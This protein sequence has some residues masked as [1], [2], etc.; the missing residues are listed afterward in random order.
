MNDDLTELRK[1]IDTVDSQLI[2]LITERMKLVAQVGRYKKAHNLPSLD[3][4]R[5]QEVLQNRI[6]Q[7]QEISAETIK[8]IWNALH[9]EA[10]QVEEEVK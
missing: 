8:T 1:Q 10:L 9:K 2:K 4:T 6:S 5:W 3:Q 7:A